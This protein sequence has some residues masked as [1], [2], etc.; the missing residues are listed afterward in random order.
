MA[1]SN[2]FSFCSCTCSICALSELMLSTRHALRLATHRAAPLVAQSSTLPRWPQLNP[3]SFP[4]RA[5]IDLVPALPLPV[6]EGI[7]SQR[8]GPSINLH[9]RF[10]TLGDWLRL[11]R[12]APLFI[13]GQC[14]A[15][16]LRRSLAAK[17]N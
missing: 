8:G 11:G 14:A 6:S 15:K 12:A 10:Q 3:A 7:L 4:T 17:R 9:A 5:Q 1:C 13:F 16:S 2:R